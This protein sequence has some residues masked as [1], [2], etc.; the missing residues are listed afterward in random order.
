[1]DQLAATKDTTKLRTCNH[2]TGKQSTICRVEIKN[3]DNYKKYIFFIVLGNG[4]VSLGM[5]EIELL[6]ILNINCTTIGT[7]KEK[8]GVH[9]NMKKDSI[10]SA[11]SEQCYANTSPERSSAKTNSNVRCSTTSC[12]NSNLNKRLHNDLIPVVTNDEIECSIPGPSTVTNTN[13]HNNSNFNNRPDDAPLLN[14]YEIKYL[15]PGPSK[16]SDNQ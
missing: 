1:M 15:L 10:L 11:G 12:S 3:Y 7:E 4:E 5:P 14:N 16:E 9:C 13:N 6:S 2:T 8:K